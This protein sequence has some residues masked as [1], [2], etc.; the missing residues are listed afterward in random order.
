MKRLY[1]EID[2]LFND[3]LSEYLLEQEGIEKINIDDKDKFIKVE[4]SYNDKI[5]PLI[6][7]KYIKLFLKEKNAILISFNKNSNNSIHSFK[8]TIEN[9]CCEYCYK[10]LIESLFE[11][12]SVKS[13]QTNYNY[14]N[15]KSRIE[16]NIEIN[17]NITKEKVID[18]IKKNK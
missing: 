1:L 14:D 6:I 5:S 3:E 8:Y 7:Y 13:I 15:I 18:C 10:G 2:G 11:I 4:I 17:E 9:I 16:F 12:D